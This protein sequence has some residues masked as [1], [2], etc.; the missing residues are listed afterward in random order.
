M[1]HTLEKL[2]DDESLKLFSLHALGQD[3]SI[4]DY[5]EVSKRV[6]NYC[7]GLPLALEVLGSS[8]SGKSVDLWKSALDKLEAIP[9]SQILEKLKISYDSLQDDHDQNLFL[10]IACFSVGMEKK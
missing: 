1:V 7:A 5:T 9:E 10:H 6:V 3:H 4:E 8:L 2:N